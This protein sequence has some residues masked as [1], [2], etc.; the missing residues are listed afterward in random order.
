MIQDLIIYTG[1]TTDIRHFEV[2]GISESVVITILQTYI[3]KGHA[4]FVD[5]WY[6]SPTLFQSFLRENT[7][8]Q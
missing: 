3:R 7:G 1:A 2:L 8:A 5:N 6:S 4:V